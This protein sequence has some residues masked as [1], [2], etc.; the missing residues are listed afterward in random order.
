WGD[1]SG[2]LLMPVFLMSFVRMLARDDE[3]LH[4]AT[5]RGR[6]LLIPAG[7]LLGL[8]LYL[9]PLQGALAFPDPVRA[10]RF[11]DRLELAYLALA[12]GYPRGLLCL[13]LWRSPRARTRWRLTSAGAAAAASLLPPVL[14]YLLPLALGIA[15]GPI[16]DL[17]LLPLGVAPLGFAAT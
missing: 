7:L 8:A 17:A 11:K 5:P 13:G 2:R 16:G 1:L 4:A 14:L 12:A 15:P 9:I 10:I 6:W 3:T